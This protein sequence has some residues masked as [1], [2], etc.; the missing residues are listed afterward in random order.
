MRKL[1]PLSLLPWVIVVPIMLIISGCGASRDLA[2]AI[3]ELRDDTFTEGCVFDEVAGEAG[4]GIYGQGGEME[5]R[6]F[7]LKCSANLP[8]DYCFRYKNPNTGAEGQ[9]GPGCGNNEPQEVIIVGPR[10]NE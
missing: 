6:V 3:D 2:V 8:D 9:A 7:K 10:Q 5:G 4:L 1:L